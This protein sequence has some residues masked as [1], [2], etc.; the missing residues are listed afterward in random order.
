MQLKKLSQ[1]S[2]SVKIYEYVKDQSAAVVI[3]KISEYRVTNLKTRKF[4]K[5]FEV[6]KAMKSSK[7]SQL[8]LNL[9]QN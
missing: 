8:H 1:A 9:K 7:R 2:K 5:V 4:L 6:M 3:C